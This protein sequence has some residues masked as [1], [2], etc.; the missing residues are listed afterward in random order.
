MIDSNMNR[1]LTCINQRKYKQAI[2][3]AKKF[4]KEDL[5]GDTNREKRLE[6]T[7]FI[8]KIIAERNKANRNKKKRKKKWLNEIKV[9]LS[10]KLLI[11]FPE[12]FIVS[13]DKSKV[14]NRQGKVRP[15]KELVKIYEREN[16][17]F[18]HH[19]TLEQFEEVL[20]EMKYK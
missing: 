15:E 1:I 14:E 16:L 19:L 18:G 7:K 11:F 6:L 5:P 13:Y 4:K 3:I 12:H 17:G 8:E 9:M 20:K 10:Q 2:L